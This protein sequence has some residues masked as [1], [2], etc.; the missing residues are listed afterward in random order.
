MRL[1]EEMGGRA[2]DAWRHG[3]PLTGAGKGA[4][5]IATRMAPWAAIAACAALTW[6]VI[7]LENSSWPM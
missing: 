4:G 2:L 1:M 7:V 5:S 3:A 6:A